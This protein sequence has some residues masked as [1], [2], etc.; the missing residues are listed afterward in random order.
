MQNPGVKPSPEALNI[1]ATGNK[2]HFAQWIVYSS[3]LWILKSSLLVLYIRLTV[4]PLHTFGRAP[5][6]RCR[7]GWLVHFRAVSS[8]ASSSSLLAG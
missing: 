5:T 1:M 6:Y 8:S 3:T 2:F 4:S 7:L